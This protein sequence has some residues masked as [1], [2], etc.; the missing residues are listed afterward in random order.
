MIMP[1]MNSTS[2]RDSGGSIALVDGGSVLPGFPG[3]PG[4]TTTGLPESFCCADTADDT[5]TAM[6]RD[7][8]KHRNGVIAFTTGSQDRTG[9]PA[10]AMLRAGASRCHL[11]VETCAT[12]GFVGGAW[13]PCHWALVISLWEMPPMIFF[14]G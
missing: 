9:M 4:W 10:I 6:L 11:E 8:T 1:R 13:Q 5:T 7:A 3:A 2:A 14:P 12:R